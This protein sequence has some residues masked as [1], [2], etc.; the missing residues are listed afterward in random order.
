MDEGHRHCL[1][2]C[3][4]REPHKGQWNA[5]GGKVREGETPAQACRREIREETGLDLEDLRPMGSVDCLDLGDPANAW[6]LYLFL[7]CHPRVP[8]AA[9]EEG[10]FAW[11]D[12]GAVLAGGR[13]FVHNIPFILP[14]LLRGLAI[15]G[16]FEYR[17]NFL[18]RY[19]I[20]LNTESRGLPI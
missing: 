6:R 3:R 11:L 14:P 18:E 5:P 7:G 9:R 12:L 13:E 20:S 2:L 17:D 1:M 10:H 16:V 8:V 4:R 15:R 19:Y